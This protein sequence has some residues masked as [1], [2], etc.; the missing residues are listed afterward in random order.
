MSRSIPCII[1]I[2][3][4]AG[5]GKTTFTWKFWE[6]SKE[7]SEFNIAPVNFDPATMNLPYKPIFDIRDY[8]TARKFMEEF[9]LGPNGAIVKA[10]EESEKYLKKL[11][12]AIDKSSCDYILLDTPGI[13][14]VFVGREVGRRIVDSLLERYN[15]IGLFIMDS[16]IITKPSE[17][18]YFK[19]L[20]ILSGLKLGIITVPV[21][22]KISKASKV[23]KEISDLGLKELI[24]KLYS[25]P[26]LYTDAAERLAKMIDELE[27]AVR[28]LKVDSLL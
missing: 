8:V 26:G 3:G 18:I 14:E 24:E 4:P 15:I 11:F 9:G 2:Y 13:M 20:F 21:W 17:Y 5:S 25:E 16:S 23:F 27:Y 28:F 7:N 1:F 22:N 12:E 19:S 10:V 6:W